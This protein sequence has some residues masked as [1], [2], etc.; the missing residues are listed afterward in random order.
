MKK[1]IAPKPIAASEL[2]TVRMVA[3]REK[4]ISRVIEN[5]SL[6]EWVGI[7]WITLRKATKRDRMTYRT[8]INSEPFKP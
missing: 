7:G 3:G 1:R 4:H 2:H 5:G 6:V 8:V